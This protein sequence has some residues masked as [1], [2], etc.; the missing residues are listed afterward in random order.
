MSVLT[1]GL[2]REATGE[3]RV[4]MDDGG[5]NPNAAIG[6]G[7]TGYQPVPPGYQP[8]GTGRTFNL[9][10]DVVKNSRDLLLPRGTG[11]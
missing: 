6:T 8:G 1:G 4:G 10:I 11:W 5:Q 7:S 2:G 3:I 9:E